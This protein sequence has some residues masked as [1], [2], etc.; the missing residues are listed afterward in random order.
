MANWVADFLAKHAGIDVVKR[1]RH[2]LHVK[3]PGGGTVGHF[4]GA[5]M[6]YLDA[7]KWLPLDTTLRELSPGTYGAPGLDVRLTKDGLVRIAGTDHTQS[8]Q[9]IGVFDPG[10]GAFRPVWT[11]PQGEVDGDRVIREGKGWEH[12]LWLTESGLRETVTLLEAPA[13]P[14]QAEE[15]LALE[16]AIGGMAA[17]DGEVGEFSRVGFAFPT[18]T[19]IDARGVMAACKRYWRDGNLYTGVPLSWLA[20]AVYP[21][22]MDPDFAGDAA[23]GWVEGW[24]AS[25]ATARSTSYTHGVAG[26]TIYVG[27]LM[28]YGVLRGFLKFDTS[29]I[30]A[31]STVAQVNLRLVCTDD[32]SATDFAVEIVKHNWAGQ[33]PMTASNREAAYDGCLAADLDDHIW[34][35][36]SGIATNT[37]YTSDTLAPS[38][39]NTT[40]PTY[41]GLRSYEDSVASTPV[42]NEYVFVGAAENATAAYRPV[43]VVTYEG[44]GAGGETLGP[45]RAYYARRRAA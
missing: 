18:P 37:P 15:C 21:V 30:G 41:Y 8:T 22:T 29:S 2:A 4:T 36:T 9:R 20:T 16:T 33:D 26:T 32:Y 40:A 39:V 23:D 13:V 5:P 6:H 44:V 25:Y 34:R 45:H 3:E 27:Q 24:N 14:G 38:W 1:A 43:L 17:V 10:T 42:D 7:G 11:L 28:G 12:E 19:A 35:N 31:G